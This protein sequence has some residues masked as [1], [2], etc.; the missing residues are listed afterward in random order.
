MLTRNC[1]K[2]DEAIAVVCGSEPEYVAAISNRLRPDQMRLLGAAFA[3]PILFTLFA[4]EI[5]GIEAGF[6]HLLP[7]QEFLHPAIKCSNRHWPA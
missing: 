6:L 3:V 1:S 5:F 2:S 7:F 4:L